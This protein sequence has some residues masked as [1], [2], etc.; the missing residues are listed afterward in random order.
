MSLIMFLKPFKST[1]LY[2]PYNVNLKFQLNSR[3]TPKVKNQ[4]NGR[5]HTRPSKNFHCIV[6]KRSVQPL[7]VTLFELSAHQPMKVCPFVSFSLIVTFKICC[8][9]ILRCSC[10]KVPSSSPQILL[11]LPESDKPFRQAF[12]HFHSTVHPSPTTLLSSTVY[13]K[14]AN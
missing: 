11:A 5:Q 2:T 10:L 4:N 12:Y 1:S 8:N 9:P 3:V 6:S 14:E 13:S 7:Q